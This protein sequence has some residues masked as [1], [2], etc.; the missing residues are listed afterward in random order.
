MQQTI[1]IPAISIVIPTY[2]I[3]NYI[4]Q[5]LETVLSQTFKDFEVIVIDD[6]STDRTVEVIESYQS[7]FDG[8]LRLY[9]FPK[10]TNDGAATPKNFG[11]HHARGKYVIFIDG[12]DLLTANALNDFITAAEKFQA[13]LV[14]PE[15]FIRFSDQGRLPKQSE[16][17]IQY[18]RK[19]E[20]RVKEPTLVGSSPVDKVRQ[21]IAGEVSDFYWSKFTRREFL[22][23][24][25]IEFSKMPVRH[26]SIFSFS[27]FVLGRSVRIPTIA[28]GYRIGRKNA[29]SG[30]EGKWDETKIRKWLCDI[31]MGT[32]DL[33]NFCQSLEIFAQDLRLEYDVINWFL[34][35]EFA[36]SS[37]QIYSSET[38]ERIKQ[39][40]IAEALKDPVGFIPVFA[41]IFNMANGK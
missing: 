41:Q 13:D 15:S 8:R 18:Q 31:L 35:H 2:N 19:P 37:P 34:R 33:R 14:F 36:L 24:H 29:N 3:E 30:R 4:N 5:C 12:D 39:I 28:N 11:L 16:I 25:E 7:R 22:L 38:P 26:D 32:R 23:D 10:N 1:S 40:L 6:Y 20:I 27:C 9:K 17:Q 21:Y